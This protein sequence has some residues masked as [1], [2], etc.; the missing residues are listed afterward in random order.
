MQYF[1]GLIAGTVAACTGSW[2]AFTLQKR[3]DRELDQHIFN[4][5][6]EEIISNLEMLSANC[7]ELE[8]EIAIAGSEE[9]ITGL[10]PFYFPTWDILK[11]HVPKE[12]A[13]K[14]AFR[15]IAL[16]MHLT[17]VA[18]NEIKARDQF[19]INGIS[20]HGYKDELKAR[21][22][23][24]IERHAAL[25]KKFLGLMETLD[26]QIKF[27][28]PSKRLTEAINKLRQESDRKA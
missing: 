14:D 23:S 2:F 21:D 7:N 25:L 16:V 5:F 1:L 27:S 11:L 19:K 4:A 6:K 22:E 24:I 9:L 26:M 15:Q 3:K 13:D 18:N 20:T 12:L 17:L 8:K 28:S 10:S